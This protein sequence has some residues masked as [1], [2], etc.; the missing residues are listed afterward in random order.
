VGDTGSVSAQLP[1]GLFP[2][3]WLVVAAVGATMLW[4]GRRL[5]PLVVEPLPVVVKAVEST[6]GRGRLYRRVRDREHAAA[7]LRAATVRRL[8]VRL[9]LPVATGPDRLARV[10]ADLTGNP[11]DTVREVL[12]TRPVGDDAALTRLAGDLA[13]L[14]REVHST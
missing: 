7:V 3:L 14:E 2:A 10:V 8:V 9:R 4:R 11:V 13:R 6:Q 5:G 1:R 12:A